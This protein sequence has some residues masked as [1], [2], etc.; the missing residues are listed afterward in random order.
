MI[1]DTSLLA[2]YGEIIE[3]MAE[4]HRKVMSYMLEKD[5]QTNCELANR[6]GWPINT[7][8][9]RV[10]ELRAA[11]HVVECCRRECGITGRKAICW[12]LKRVVGEQA[13][14]YGFEI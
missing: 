8:T 6:L 9:P 14:L 11:G 1:Q 10:F 4:K 5:E 3:K 12:K 13:K 7:V 2:Y